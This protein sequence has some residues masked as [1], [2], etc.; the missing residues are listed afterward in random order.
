MTTKPK[1]KK[2]PKNS[3][4][5]VILENKLECVD[6]I[7][8]VIFPPTGDLDDYPSTFVVVKWKDLEIYVAQ[9]HVLFCD[10]EKKL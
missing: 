3:R 1:T 7:K 5:I 6:L 4:A 8:Q 2:F 9:T 10:E